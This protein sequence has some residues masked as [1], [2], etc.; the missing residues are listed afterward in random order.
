MDP[1]QVAQ[2]L[3]GGGAQGGGGSGMA[4]APTPQQLL[5]IQNLMKNPGGLGAMTMQPN[6]MMPPSPLM[7]QGMGQPQLGQQAQPGM[8]QMPPSQLMQQ[9]N[10]AMP[11][12][13]G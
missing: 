9:L 5:T 4:P 12:A 8:G 2:L 13:G 6:Q 7:Q 11:S 1:T 10:G 3:Q